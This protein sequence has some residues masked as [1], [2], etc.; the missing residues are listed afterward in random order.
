M[1]PRSVEELVVEYGGPLAH[2]LLDPHYHRFSSARAEGVIGYCHSW[3]CAVALGD[4]VSHPSDVTALAA[5]F[6]A[7]CAARSCDTVFAAG[8][9]PFAAEQC[10]HGAATVQFGQT[11][12][13]DP[14]YDSQAGAQG[15]ELRKKVVRAQREGVMVQ[16]Y[17]PDR[18]GHKLEFE[19]ALNDVAVLWLAAR[20]GLQMYVSHIELFPPRAVGRRWF[21]ALVGGRMVGVLTLVRMQAR[22][23]YLLQHLLAAPSSP[24]GVSELLVVTCF[25]RLAAEGCAF[26]TFGPAPADHLGATEHLGHASARIAQLSYASMSRLFH[27]DRRA[28]FQRK[29]HVSSVE[30]IYVVFDPPRVRIRDLL[31]VARAFHISLR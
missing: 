22:G 30:P 20:R 11:L 13:Y 5:E 15:R 1:Q 17:L 28:H 23:G 26:A 10:R 8:S 6:R 29:F 3:G 18:E 19:R 21:Y 16:E 9:E 4:P 2:C 24:V 12:I 7:F 27:M 31:G 14:R 25:A